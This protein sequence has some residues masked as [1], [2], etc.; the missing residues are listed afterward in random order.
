MFNKANQKKAGSPMNKTTFKRQKRKFRTLIIN[1][2]TLINFFIYLLSVAVFFVLIYIAPYM[3]RIPFGYINSFARLSFSISLPD[4]KEESLVIIKRCAVKAAGTQI[5]PPTLLNPNN[6]N[7]KDPYPNLYIPVTENDTKTTLALPSEDKNIK[8]KSFK[9]K[10]TVTIDNKTTLSI[11][12][13][14]LLSSPVPL[15]NTP[16]KPLVLI[17]HTHTTESYTPSEKYNYTPTSYARTINPDFNMIKVGKEFAKGLEEEGVAVIHDTSV[18]DY[19]SYNGSYSKTLEVIESNLKKY[20]SIQVV[21]DIHRDS[22]TASDGT[23]YKTIT[24]IDK[25]KSAQLMIISGCYQGGLSHPDWQENLKLTL[26]LQKALNSD[27]NNIARPLTVRKERFNTH[28]T[29]GS[30]LVEIGT[31]ANT[32][33]EALL[34]AKYA[35]KTFAKV[36]KEEIR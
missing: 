31:D 27:Y 21:L 26:K 7:D 2:Y 1:K 32:L 9:S 6:V 16:G 18:N 8:E 12:T 20:P 15:K 33:D 13:N 10:N 30:M 14:A 29:K 11:D 5:L 25:N 17:V 35:S 23:K 4:V 24:E 22:M 36:I 34:C 3:P 19:P 28:A